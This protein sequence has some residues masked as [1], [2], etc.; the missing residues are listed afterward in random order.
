MQ[1]SLT[2]YVLTGEGGG[3]L[4]WVGGEFQGEQDKFQGFW[5]GGGGGGGG[6]GLISMV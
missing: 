6:G 4:G 1:V 3:R 5:K 2:N